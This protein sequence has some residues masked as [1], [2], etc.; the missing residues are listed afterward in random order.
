MTFL[1]PSVYKMVKHSLSILQ[2]LL[3]NFEHAFDYSVG[4]RY[5]TVNQLIPRKLSHIL[6]ELAKVTCKIKV[7][8]LSIDKSSQAVSNAYYTLTDQQIVS[9]LSHYCQIS[10]DVSKSYEMIIILT[11]NIVTL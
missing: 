10:I 6:I 1:K 9:Q 8:N 11:V 4:T 5:Y 7:T 3:Q 2:Q